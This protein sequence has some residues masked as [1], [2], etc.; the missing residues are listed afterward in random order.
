MS[1]LATPPGR[2]ARGAAAH[3]SG[4]RRGVTPRRANADR[5]QLGCAASRLVDER[6]LK[7]SVSRGLLDTMSEATESPTFRQ[8]VEL[9]Q[10]GDP[11]AAEKV[12]ADAAISARGQ[13]GRASPQDAAAQFDLAKILVGVGDL[14][15]A[16]EALREASTLQGADDPSTKD[17]LT[18]NM[19]LGEVLQRLGELEEAESVLRD[20]LLDREA[21]YGEEHPGYA[22]GLEP[23]ADVLRQR[24][25]LEEAI[26]LITE[27]VLVLWNHGHPHVVSALAKR[28]SIAKALGGEAFNQLETLPEELFERLVEEV[29]GRV[30]LDEPRVALGV[31]T[32]L[33]ECVVRRRGPEESWLVNIVAAISSAARAAGD[34][35]ARREALRWL[36]DC[37]QTR[38]DA[39]QMIN[40]L[41]GLGLAED[42]A[43]M[44]DAADAS[45]RRALEAA[46]QLGDPHVRTT[47]A[48]NYGLF[49]AEHGRRDEAQVMLE[50]A[51][52][53]ARETGDVPAVGKALVA[54]GIFRQ[55]EGQ[56]DAAR[57]LLQEAI[58]R[59]EPSHPD[60]LFA[61]SH[62]Q[63]IDSGGSCGCGDMGAA[64]GEALK[65]MVLEQCPPGLV[66]RL[67]VV[68]D[69]QS[70]PRFEVS[71][72]RE[73]QPGEATQLE[74]VIHQATAELR[75]RIRARG[76]SG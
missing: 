10:A 29:L 5:D 23:L 76:L 47:V 30:E 36:V 19:N 22:F 71:L 75:Q 6:R 9:L 28:A 59:L 69:E 24:G 44:A 17:R 37:Q 60:A 55:H 12:V 56:L 64:I 33:Q 54:C 61:R 45:Y 41:L 34:H 4:E 13:H 52:L 62:L 63:A 67:E 68:L 8:A 15:R 40:A 39:P 43:G 2:N 65:A 46:D 72:A 21:F 73:P 70:E 7:F 35:E 32:E 51:L 26:E 1:W 16:A 3:G 25:E 20:G 53:L 27:A 57:A 48:R 18:Y 38:G 66:D 50:R 42:E 11:L 49:L 74:R 58:E 31:L 14:R